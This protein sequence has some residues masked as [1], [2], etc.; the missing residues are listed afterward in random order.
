MWLC[1]LKAAT[2]QLLSETHLS[3]RDEAGQTQETALRVRGTEMP[4]ALPDVLSSD[5]QSVFMRHVK[6][7]LEGRRVQGEPTP[8]LFSS[9]GYLDDHNWHRTYWIYG[10]DFNS[11]WGGW[12]RVG[13][14]VPSGRLLVMSDSEVFGFGR[15]F[16]PS[17]NA[18]Q[19][20]KGEVYRFFAAPKEFEVPEPEVDQRKRRRQRAVVKDKSVVPCRWSYPADMEARAM[21]LADDML[22][23]AGPLGDT[24]LSLDAF[25]G[26]EGIRLRALSTADGS[27]QGEYKLQSLPVFNGM[28]VARGKLYL[29]TKDG[30]LHCFSGD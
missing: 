13:N 17:G 5:G 22:F 12:W 18:Y 23:V 16:M 24:R 10:T 21:A 6:F 8:H 14:K 29:T 26:K 9:V 28:A 19:W 4:G 11:G 2:G 7:D 30:Q 1:R 15:S 27:V 20:R 3:G 25:E